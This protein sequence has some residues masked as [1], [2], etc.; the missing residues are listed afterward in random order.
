MSKSSLSVF[1]SYSHKDEN[2]RDELAEHLATLNRNGEIS[3]WHDRKIA[4]GS[5]WVKAID[6]NLK[7]A[8]VILLL[9]SSSFL[10]SDYCSKIELNQAIARHNSGESRVIPIILRPCD[11]QSSQFGKLQALPKDAK[12]ITKWDDKDEAFYDV[13]KGVRLAIDQIIKSQV[14]YVEPVKTIS[15][16]R[17]T[18]IETVNERLKLE[19]PI[20]INPVKL[21]SAKG[22]DY[23]ELEKLLKAKEWRSADKLTG[24][25]MC[26]VTKREEEGWLDIKHIET[27]PFDDLRTIDQLWVYHSNSKFGFS[28]LK[29]LWLEC[30]GEIGKYDYEVWKKFAAKT[31]WYHPQ[32]DNWR[33]YT[34]FMNDT[35]NTQKA[36]PASLPLA[37]GWEGV[38]F[39]NFNSLFSCRDL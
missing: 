23:R 35:K 2:L 8:D 6:D 18:N 14:T 9:I 15:S 27:F 28:I 17:A 31:G 1:F 37:W 38:I 34:E 3:V 22:I 36:L 29:K 12:P 13:V 32:K 5:D 25:L 20:N 11:W 24:K 39:G 26:Q 7:T 33:T 21:R 19:Y 4:A 16:M 30:G 10:A